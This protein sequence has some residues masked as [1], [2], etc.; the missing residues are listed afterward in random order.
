MVILNGL[1]IFSMRF[2]CKETSFCYHEYK[3]V[4]VAQKIFIIISSQMLILTF[5][6][7]VFYLS[8][9]YNDS[10]QYWVRNQTKILL[11]F[12]QKNQTQPFK[13]IKNCNAFVNKYYFV[14]DRFWKFLWPNQF[15]K[16]FMKFRVD[17]FIISV[18]NIN[19]K[20]GM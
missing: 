18:C 1:L 13:L 11:V 15:F 14:T 19:V 7:Q 12:C 6:Q 4:Y 10:K 17:I 8:S 9:Y 2:K 5:F 16:S 3:T 20:K